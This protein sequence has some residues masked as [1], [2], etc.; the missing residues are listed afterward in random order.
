MSRRFLCLNKLDA[1]TES[2]YFVLTDELDHYIMGFTLIR[3][4]RTRKP[5]RTNGS[6]SVFGKS[7][8]GKVRL[9]QLNRYCYRGNEALRARSKS[10]K[11]ANNPN[12]SRWGASRK[13]H[14]GTEC[15]RRGGMMVACENV[16]WVSAYC[17][18]W[19]REY[20]FIG[21]YGSKGFDRGDHTRS[22]KEKRGWWK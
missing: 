19:T 11:T 22:R 2:Q 16:L 8:P 18:C 6:E 10:A 1:Q 15:R 4:E 7:Q 9:N 5:K 17:G 13:R 14:D 20:V 12:S 3:G 21:L